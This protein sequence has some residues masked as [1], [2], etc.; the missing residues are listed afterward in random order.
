MQE[1]KD[2]KKLPKLK[3]RLIMFTRKTFLKS[4]SENNLKDYINNVSIHF[5]ISVI[6]SILISISVSTCHLSFSHQVIVHINLPQYFIRK[7]VPSGVSNAWSWY[8]S[9]PIFMEYVSLYILLI[10]FPSATTYFAD[11]KL[12]AIRRRLSFSAMSL[13]RLCV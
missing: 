5:R 12:F 3:Q 11:A 10:F 9:L 8:I 13:Q 1:R 4:G 6:T 2:G 7:K